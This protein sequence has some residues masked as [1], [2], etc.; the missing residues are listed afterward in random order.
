MCIPAEASFRIAMDEEKRAHQGDSFP[1]N[2]AAVRI[3]PEAVPCPGAPQLFRASPRR[4][5]CH[6]GHAPAEY[7]STHWR[8]CSDFIALVCGASIIPPRT[9][10]LLFHL[11]FSHTLKADK[12]CH[13]A[14]QSANYFL[15]RDSYQTKFHK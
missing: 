5:V 8:K 3:L 1:S 11:L 10:V 12:R 9:A 4:Q 7:D 14:L 6:R 13:V 15:E 2:A